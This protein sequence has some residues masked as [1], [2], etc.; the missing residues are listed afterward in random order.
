MSERINPLAAAWHSIMGLRTTRPRPAGD[1]VM[2]HRALQPVLDAVAVSG[3]TGI[4]AVR[5]QLDSYRTSLEAVSPNDLTAPHALAYWINAYNA[6]ALYVADRAAARGDGSVFR[7]PGAF[8]R[9]VMTTGGESLAL[10][11]IE[12]GKVRRFRDP[13]IHAALVCGAV[14]CPT[15]RAE[16]FSGDDVGAQLDDQMRRFLAEGG[17]ILSR[18]RSR[19]S[20]SRIFL[21]YG[22][23]FV[24][25]KS[26]PAWWPPRRRRL[27][28]ALT[29]WMDDE[30]GAW[31]RRTRPR[32]RFLDYDYA[33]GC[34][35]R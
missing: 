29:P 24:R 35:V 16:P 28:T 5:D 9:S 8:D 26:M 21:W 13:R 10:V 7:S 1:G 18:S 20:L 15:L 11:H 4:A 27:L 23:D 30:D 14:S 25:P 22:A 6:N 2:D 32:V 12:H 31:V 3:V 34:R 19:A 17:V 33:L